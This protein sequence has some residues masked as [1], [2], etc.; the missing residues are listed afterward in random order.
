MSVSTP[1]TLCRV[2]TGDG[3]YLDGSLGGADA[4]HTDTAFLLVH[5]TLS[6]FYAPGPL[7]RLA[8][9]ADAAGFATLR[10]NTRGHDGMCSVSGPGGSVRGGATNETVGD[11]SLDLSAWIDFLVGRD[12]SRVILVGHS[13]GGVKAVYSQAFAEHPAVAGIVCLSPPRFSHEHWIKHPDADAFRAS[14]DEAVKLVL[15]GRS[16]ELLACRQPLPFVITASAFVEKYGPDDRYDVVALLSQINCPV[17]VTVG[18]TTVKASPAFDSLP[19][20]ILSLTDQNYPVTLE[21]IDGEDMSYSLDPAG[22]FELI[23]DWLPQSEQNAGI[24]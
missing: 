6:N 9:S 13:M 8:A 16:D 19:D 20:E 23:R 7:E 11:C 12:Y 17:L 2:T 3:L 21:V 15:G 5:G 4:A 1:R 18:S 10:V 22:L 24:K 14:F